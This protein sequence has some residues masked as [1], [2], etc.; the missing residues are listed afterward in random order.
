MNIKLFV[1]NIYLSIP[2]VCVC[3][4]VCVWNLVTFIQK[5]VTPPALHTYSDQHLMESTS[6]RKSRMGI[7]E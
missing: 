7:C 2:N 6:T 3:V 4:C 1:S 5:V